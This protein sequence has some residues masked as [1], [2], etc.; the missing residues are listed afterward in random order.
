MSVLLISFINHRKYAFMR[1]LCALQG[2]SI[3]SCLKRKPPKQHHCEQTPLCCTHLHT[4]QKIS[5]AA[6]IELWIY[7]NNKCVWVCEIG[8]P[9]REWLS[10]K[11]NKR[12][13][14][15]VTSSHVIFT[16]NRSV[17]EKE[18][19]LLAYMIHTSW[20]CYVWCTCWNLGSG[21]NRG[22]CVCFWVCMLV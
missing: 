19:C 4:G 20:G 15:L 3:S 12:L 8:K 7:N 2:Y 22:V 18:D 13:G 6:W 17:V 9:H 21:S 16:L 1:F 5:H 11:K 14:F 10:A